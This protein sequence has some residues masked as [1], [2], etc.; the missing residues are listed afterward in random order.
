MAPEIFKKQQC[1]K[2]DIWACGI[3]LYILFTGEPP[4]D[5]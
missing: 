5:L 1:F 4:F 3:I 2:S